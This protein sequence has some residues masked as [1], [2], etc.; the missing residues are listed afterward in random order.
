M[1]EKEQLQIMI[2]KK[3]IQLSEEVTQLRDDINSINTKITWF[4]RILFAVIALIAAYYGYDFHIV[5]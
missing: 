5:I 3:L 4:I 2:L 1:Q